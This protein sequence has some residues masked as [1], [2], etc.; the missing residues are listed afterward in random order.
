MFLSSLL[1]F[2]LIKAH[3]SVV[4]SKICGIMERSG[5]R[6]FGAIQSICCAYRRV[7]V[8]FQLLSVLRPEEVLEEHILFYA[9]S[10]P[11]LMCLLKAGCRRILLV[12][13]NSCVV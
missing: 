11:N 2:E 5:Y 3:G 13:Y 1:T 12:L 6:D 10:I 7:E 8:H 9:E 4:S